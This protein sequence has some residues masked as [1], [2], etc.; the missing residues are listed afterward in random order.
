[1]R[2]LSQ[3]PCG[4]ALSSLGM[5]LLWLSLAHAQS[6]PTQA[7]DQQVQEQYRQL[8]TAEL[9]PQV[10]APQWGPQLTA[11]TTQLRVKSNQY[12]LKR[13]Q[14]ELAEQRWL[15]TNEQLRLATET[16]GAL[17]AELDQLKTAPPAPPP[18]N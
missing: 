9:V 10:T 8:S 3:G 15:Q 1:M 7:C 14:A 13:N 11:I 12:E 4:L 17:R 18:A 5:S 2:L 16:I 6:P